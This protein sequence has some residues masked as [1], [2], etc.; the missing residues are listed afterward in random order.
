LKKAQENFKK[1]LAEHVWSG[2]FR[3]VCCADD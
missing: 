1:A 2:G 3:V